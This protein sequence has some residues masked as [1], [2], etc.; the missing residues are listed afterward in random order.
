VRLAVLVL[1]GLVA[2]VVIAIE[3]MGDP[4]AAGPKRVVALDGPGGAESAPV[5]SFSEAVTSG[6]ADLGAGGAVD[7][8]AE[9]QR[10]RPL[11]RAPIAGL[12]ER[13]PLGPL[14]IV[15]RDGRTPA[16]AYAK[17]Y[18]PDSRRKIALVVGGLGSN[19]RNT[20]QAIEELPGEV[21]LSFLPYTR[22][23]QN[24]INRARARGHEVM[25]ELP[26]EGSESESAR[27]GPQT[28]LARASPA[29]NIQRLENLLS[30]GTGYFG[31]TNY[32]GG[33]FV[34]SAG[35]SAPIAQ[36]IKRRGLVFLTNGIG[37]R[38]AFAFEAARAALPVAAVDRVL[39]VRGGADA[40]DE[41]LVALESIAMQKGSA[42]GVGFAY[43]VTMEQISL[44]SGA[45]RGR[46]VALAPASA[47]I[48]ARTQR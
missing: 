22:N 31:V 11:A 34:A 29:Q 8:G 3:T 16:A 37:P 14:P 35:A 43:P 39:D 6:D 4:A 41:E 48:A 46:G 15:A 44:W 36:Q 13:G 32:Q 9:R 1:V 25:L 30:R 17:P 38:T 42:I 20:T 7:G 23:L 27:T 21:T 33:R 18:T 47:V 24:W 10:A 28:L 40:I 5:V 45:L 19:V 12:T 2:I 26:M